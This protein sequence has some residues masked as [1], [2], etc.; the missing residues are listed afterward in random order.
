MERNDF[1]ELLAKAGRI[2]VQSASGTSLPLAISAEV[3][4]RIRVVRDEVIPRLDAELGV[5]FPLIE[6]EPVCWI[7]KAE[8]NQAQIIYS[9]VAPVQIDADWVFGV[10]LSAV[11][12][13]TLPTE[14]L[15]GILA[16]EFLHYVQ[17]TV[18][19]REQ[20]G[21]ESSE[22]VQPTDSNGWLSP[23]LVELSARVTTDSVAMGTARD[24]ALA[25]WIRMGLPIA[26]APQGFTI[27]DVILHVAIIERQR[28]LVAPDPPAKPY[29]SSAVWY[30]TSPSPILD[31]I[32]TAVLM[33]RVGMANNALTANMRGAEAA[34]TLDGAAKMAAI[35][36]TLVTAAALT[37]EAIQLARPHM[38]ALRRLAERIGAKP[39]LFERVGLLWS[40]KH[41]AAPLLTRAR[42]K[43]GFHWD[44]DIVEPSVR[45]FG[46]NKTLVWL[47]LDAKDVRVDRLA[48]DVLAHAL[49]PEANESQDVATQQAAVTKALT[50]V[51]GAMDIVIEFFTACT[52]GYMLD[53]YA[54][55]QQRPSQDAGRH[56]D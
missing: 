14:L 32:S 56:N 22:A 8:G 50:D 3:A 17:R 36:S 51:S 53:S 10:H 5:P 44:E 31:D 23:R 2:R 34:K 45:D 18:W 7:L 16:L 46:R 35:L 24:R 47:E 39:V 49:I 20:R 6:V 55:R 48:A 12:L 26:D 54:R 19:A 52:Y 33:V 30:E 37:Y 29:A 15:E 9:F 40:G 28:S 1:F 13:L 4:Q 11:A 41:A 38:P 42:N 25:Q 21:H 43:L 27:S